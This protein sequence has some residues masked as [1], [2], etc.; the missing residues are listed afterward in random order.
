MASGQPDSP[1]VRD[2]TPSSDER[3]AEASSAT[4]TIVAVGLLPLFVLCRQIARERP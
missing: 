2:V 4:L 1:E 3:L